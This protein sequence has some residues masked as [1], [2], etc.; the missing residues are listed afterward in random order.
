M[1]LHNRNIVVDYNDVRVREMLSLKYSS[2]WPW[3]WKGIAC[4]Y[5]VVN[6]TCNVY[7][8][9]RELKEEKRYIACLLSNERIEFSDRWAVIFII[10]VVERERLRERERERDHID[11][12]GEAL[13]VSLKN[14]TIARLSTI[15][16]RMSMH[17]LHTKQTRLCKNYLGI[18]LIFS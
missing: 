3:L 2:S 12:L 7:V 10:F 9:I 6:K 17:A 18:V 1:K 11:K 16:C 5:R 13:N 8:N 4:A 14:N 15:L